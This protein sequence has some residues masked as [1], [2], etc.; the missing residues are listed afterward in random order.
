[1]SLHKVA[2]AGVNVY[3]CPRCEELN[4]Q[5]RGK[6]KIGILFVRLDFDNYAKM[7]AYGAINWAAKC[8]GRG[9]HTVALVLERTKQPNEYSVR[10]A[11]GEGR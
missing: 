2:Q 4:R 7:R 10:S 8:N 1:M 9:R 5:T 6:T 11:M 3:R